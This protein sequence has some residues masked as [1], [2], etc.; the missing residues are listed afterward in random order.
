MGREGEMS[1]EIQ[2]L[3]K[4]DKGKVLLVSRDPVGETG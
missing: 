3:D 1:L 2:V 4:D